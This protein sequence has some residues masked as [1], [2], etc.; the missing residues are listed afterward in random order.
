MKKPKEPTRKNT[1]ETEKIKQVK[2]IIKTTK[3]KTQLRN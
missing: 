2:K 3:T 1:I